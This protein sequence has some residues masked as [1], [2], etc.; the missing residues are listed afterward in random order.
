MKE[1]RR[2]QQEANIKRKQALKEELREKSLAGM[3]KT[4]KQTVKKADENKDSERI[5]NTDDDDDD[6]DDNQKGSI[7]KLWLRLVVEMISDLIS[8]F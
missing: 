8:A 1:Q 2:N 3:A 7:F 6:D 4:A 5:D